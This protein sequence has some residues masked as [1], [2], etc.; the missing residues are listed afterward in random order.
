MIPS[1]RSLSGY[2]LL[3]SLCFAPTA[4]AQVC[5]SNTT[6]WG[7]NSIEGVWLLDRDAQLNWHL[8]G[9]TGAS[10]LNEEDFLVLN[11]TPGGSISA[12]SWG[13]FANDHL[14]GMWGGDDG[15]MR[16]VGGTESFSGSKDA[17]VVRYDS[18]TDSFPW[19]RVW[20]G[21]DSDDYLGGVVVDAITGDSISAGG[22]R[23]PFTFDR[24]V[25]LLKHNSAGAL[26]GAKVWASSNS[27]G[28]SINVLR[29]DDTDPDPLNH[30]IYAAGYHANDAL[31]MQLD[32]DGNPLWVRT[33]GGDGCDDAFG[34]ELDGAGFLYMTG[35]MRLGNDC[36]EPG[37]QVFL[38]KWDLQGNLIWDVAWG[39]G[40][41][42][43]GGLSI[44]PAPDPAGGIYLSG[45][46]HCNGP[47]S[48][49]YL[50]KF[51]ADGQFL[52]S[53][54]WGGAGEDAFR[55]R[56]EG[57]ALYG[58]GFTDGCAG[59]LQ[60][61]LGT[62][63]DP[64]ATVASLTGVL[65]TA[66]GNGRYVTGITGSP[67]DTPGCFG[68][69]AMFIEFEDCPPTQPTPFCFGDGATGPACSVACPCGN[70]SAVGAGEGC[71][72]SLGFGAI[73]S[74]NGS[75]SVVADDLSFTVTQGRPNQPSM[76]V[77]GSLR[78]AIPFKDGILCMGN[79]T[80]RVEVVFLDINGE[81]TS[82][83]S[84]VTEG[85]IPGPGTLRFY[86]QWYRDPGGVSP[87]GTGSNFTQ[88]LEV[89]F[90]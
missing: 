13:G 20:D 75:T 31:L 64:A 6:F 19:A 84:I 32:L 36:D 61:C 62:C 87:C 40:G 53:K 51:D 78:V 67:G 47:D 34:L 2:L 33:W 17:V 52:W 86:Q 68:L 39:T 25:L 9:I 57:G 58:A 37:E 90:L 1:T 77:Q 12:R 72:S 65:S 5:V 56:Y 7:G 76:L 74:A 48:D 80:E 11:V 66:N 82:T 3:A 45:E 69:D 81:G 85:N 16:L 27:Q 30:R 10:D 46:T 49:S 63:A 21:G 26:L 89:V 24:D 41:D 50:V 44:D 35:S 8:A 70:N 14:E 28:E 23:L 83:S 73:L 54:S 43:G 18:A 59:V 38:C 71:K 60:E 15:S 88:G 22:T 29:I 4:Q 55:V 42:G 79:P